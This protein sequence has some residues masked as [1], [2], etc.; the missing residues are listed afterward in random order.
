MLDRLKNAS[1]A[2][3]LK[4]VIALC[5]F[6]RFFGH[7]SSSLQQRILSSIRQNLSISPIKN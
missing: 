7:C 3:Q 2:I 1:V 6:F 4:F 5:L